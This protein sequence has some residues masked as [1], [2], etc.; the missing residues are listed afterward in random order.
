M[1]KEFDAE[2]GLALSSSAARKLHKQNS[3]AVE[4]PESRKLLKKAKLVISLYVGDHIIHML[5][6]EALTQLV[7][8][9]SIIPRFLHNFK[10]EKAKRCFLRYM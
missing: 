8:F 9:G 1:E 6:A 5:G 4:Q 2:K 10:E 7:S 3:L